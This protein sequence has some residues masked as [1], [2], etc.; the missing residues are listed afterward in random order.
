MYVSARVY[1]E[2]SVY[3]IELISSWSDSPFNEYESQPLYTYV[4]KYC[5]NV[6]TFFASTPLYNTINMETLCQVETSREG[7]ETVTSSSNI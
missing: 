4:N 2:M 7:E 6:H 5:T 3:S 1:T